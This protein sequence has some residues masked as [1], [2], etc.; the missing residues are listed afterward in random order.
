MKDVLFTF[1]SPYAS[2]LLGAAYNIQQ[3]L[4]GLGMHSINFVDRDP[5]GR[6][7]ASYWSA[8]EAVMPIFGLLFVATVWIA[9]WTILSGYVVARKRGAVYASAL[10]AFPG[11]L[12][13]ASLW[14]RLSSI[15]ATYFVGGAGVYGST[16]GTVT[17][18]IAGMLLGWSAAILLVDICRFR[19]NFWYL[20][21]HVWTALGLLAGIFF[22]IDAQTSDHARDL[23]E[24]SSTSQ[25]ASAYLL[26]QALAYRTWCQ[27]TGHD[28]AL[29]CQWAS[30]VQQ[31]LADYTTSI[32]A[33]FAIVG[34]KSSADMYR[35]NRK[36]R[37]PQDILTIRKE[38]AAYNRTICPIQDLGNGVQKLAPTSE[39]CQMTPPIFCPVYPDPIDG[40]IDKDD[41]L[42]TVAISSECIIPALVALR[43][44]QEG[45]NKQVSSD[46]RGKTYRWLYYLILSVLA[47]AKIAGST[48]KLVAMD[49]REDPA[50]RRSLY[51]L[52]KLAVL[53]VHFIRY[54]WSW[55]C[56]FS[57]L[58]YRLTSSFIRSLRCSWARTCRVFATRRKIGEEIREQPQKCDSE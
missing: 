48:V 10:I 32:P 13:L 36:V 27:E 29:S 53:P 37:G 58:L 20:Y 39:R 17:L 46:K 22:V 21:D 15:P 14:P 1:L 54:V 25:S 23:Q 2:T 35:V 31:T 7:V 24:S 52:R 6:I 41:V 55:V 49:D 18:V 5:Q 33:I 45:L 47:G 50:T 38:I 30:D 26:K 34:P 11:C 19:K 9:C 28:N 44:T 16:V 12:S 57:G 43:H 56:A 51:V 40:K 42:S 3:A 4:D 8:Q